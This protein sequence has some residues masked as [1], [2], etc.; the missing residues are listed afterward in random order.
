MKKS[1]LKL[2]LA[3]LLV[4][5]CILVWKKRR[6]IVRM[7]HTLI[8]WG[9][10]K[11]NN[12]ASNNCACTISSLGVRGQDYHTYHIPA[13]ERQ[14]KLQY[15]YSYNIKNKLIK[16]GELEEIKADGFIVKHLEYSSMHLTP[17]AKITLYELVRRYK[18]RLKEAGI[19][20]SFLRI[21]SLTRTHSQQMAL[22]VKSAAATKKKSAHC[23]GQAFDIDFIKTKHCDKSLEALSDVLEE[24]RFEKKLLICPEKGCIHVTVI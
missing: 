16:K 5:F 2:F 12:L 3:V 21:S 22:S 7:A 24:M 6:T 18:N 19:S 23:Y 8:E 17:H 4:I 13:L 14:K 15:I 20:N 9:A 11:K 1:Y 10:N